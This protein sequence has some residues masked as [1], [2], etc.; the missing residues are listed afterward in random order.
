MI[1]IDTTELLAAS[2]GADVAADFV[3]RFNDII[4]FPLI[5]LLSGIAMLYFIYG[6]VIYIANAENSKARETGR[7]HIIYSVVGMLIML[8]AYSILMIAANTFGLNKVLDCSNN[9]LIA[10]CDNVM[11]VPGGGGYSGGATDSGGF[12][13]GGADSGGASGGAVP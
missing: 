7:R 1:S 3:S 9:P 4:L 12:G 11:R 13:G 2:P 6:C 10:G 8:I 5:M